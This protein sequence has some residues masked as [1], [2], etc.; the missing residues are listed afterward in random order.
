MFS[1]KQ[2][3]LKFK[4]I[5]SS[6]INLQKNIAKTTRYIKLRMI[7]LTRVYLSVAENIRLYLTINDTSTNVATFY[8]II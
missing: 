6:L 5:M 4:I 8:L 1:L 7:Q 2:N 3:C